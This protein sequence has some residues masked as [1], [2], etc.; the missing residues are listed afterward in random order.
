MIAGFDTY[1][2]V[3]HNSVVYHVRWNVYYNL[4]TSVTPT[5]DVDGIYEVLS[6]GAV[7]RLPTALKTVLD[8]QFPGNTVP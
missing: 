1:L 7:S 8:T 5:A 6:S 2:V 3:N 4:N